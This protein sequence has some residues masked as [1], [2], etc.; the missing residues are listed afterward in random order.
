MR[1]HERR[2][3]GYCKYGL[4]TCAQFPSYNINHL[5]SY[6]MKKIVD[7]ISHVALNN[8]K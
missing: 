7:F 6:F 5:V 1:T 8:F 3:G 2:F 4:V